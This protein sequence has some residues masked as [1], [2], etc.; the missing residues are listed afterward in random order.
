MGAQ[1]LL[2]EFAGTTVIGHIADQLLNST[3][4]EICVVV[5]DQGGRIAEELTARN[6]SI[7]ANPN[8]DEGMLSSVRCG[9]KAFGPDCSAVLIALGDQPTISTSLVDRMIHAFADA[10]KGIIVPV[11]DS[12][13]GHPLLFSAKYRDEILTHYDDVGLRGLLRAHQDD[14]AELPVDSDSVLLDMDYPED[15][16]RIVKK[17]KP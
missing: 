1:K 17:H 14:I 15:Y 9:L 4:D 12:R 3:I 10:K 7:V 16:D 6:V 2:L 13:R 5:G 8:P 11:H